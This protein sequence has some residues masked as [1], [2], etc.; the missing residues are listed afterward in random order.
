MHWITEIEHIEEIGYRMVSVV[1]C[2]KAGIT[3]IQKGR[4]EVSY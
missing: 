2:C 1:K 3:L 4:D